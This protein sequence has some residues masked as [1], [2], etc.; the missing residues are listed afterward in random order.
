MLSNPDPFY[1][2]ILIPIFIISIGFHEAAHAYAVNYFGDDTPRLQGRL[3]LN[4]IAHLDMFGSIML[5]MIG[6]GWGK[7]VEYNPNALKNDH[8]SRATMEQIIAAAGPLANFVLAF[9]SVAGLSAIFF[10]GSLSFLM[11]AFLISASLNLL[12]MFLNLIPIPPLDGSKVIRPFLPFSL[13][14]HYDGLA[15]YGSILLLALFFLPGISTVFSNGLHSLT[16]G[17]LMQMG[18]ILGL[19]ALFGA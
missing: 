5:L 13:L 2:M 1:L 11:E 10:T 18:K 15:P 14:Q 8:L 17:T 7:S 16:N 3:T 9:L 19:G 6:F 4:P 12:L